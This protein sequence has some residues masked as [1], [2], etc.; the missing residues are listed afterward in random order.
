MAAPQP[1]LGEAQP[2]VAVV[3][4]LRARQA[5]TARAAADDATAA[6][7]PQSAPTQLG[8]GVLVDALSARVRL[9]AA[10]AS[11]VKSDGAS[12]LAAPACGPRFL[13]P[14]R[15]HTRRHAHARTFGRSRR[16]SPLS[17]CRT[18]RAR[19]RARMSD[20][21]A[22]AG[23]RRGARDGVA[24]CRQV[25]A[26]AGEVGSRRRTRG[27]NAAI[28]QRVR[29]WARRRR[30]GGGV[31]IGGVKRR[32]CRG[33][34]GAASAA[35]RRELATAIGVGVRIAGHRAA[36]ATHGSPFCGRWRI[37]GLGAARRLGGAGARRPA[38]LAIAA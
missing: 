33:Q 37:E 3:A 6:P 25:S 14:A 29:G 10:S 23:V 35:A 30:G 8:V 18:N 24:A 1:P 28:D 21:G 27:A 34:G 5:A 31:A 15:R 17:P 13:P 38:R 32:A 26:A 12:H 36:A 9:H 7:R 4:A 11:A 2:A 20:G 22:A 19:L 16:R